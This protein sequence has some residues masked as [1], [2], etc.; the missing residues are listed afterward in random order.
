EALRQIPPTAREQLCRT[1]L[2]YMRRELVIKV[3]Y[4]DYS[5]QEEIKQQSSQHLVAPWSIDEDEEMVYAATLYPRS[6]DKDDE[7]AVRY[8]SGLSSY[9]RYVRR[10]LRVY[11]IDLKADEA[12]EVIRDLLAGLS[13]AGLIE[14]VVEPR[15]EN[16]VP[17]YQLPA[18]TIIWREGHQQTVYHD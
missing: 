16:G 9:G 14:K 3:D 2:D 12:Q 11:N 8:L 10:I 15:G 4:L 7:R 13:D 1:L 18:S 6:R 5:R 17:G